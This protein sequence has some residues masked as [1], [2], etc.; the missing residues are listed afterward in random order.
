MSRCTNRANC[1]GKL[2]QRCSVSGHTV[3]VV[4][5]NFSHPRGFVERIVDVES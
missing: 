5:C 4:F 2:A 1:M 3:F